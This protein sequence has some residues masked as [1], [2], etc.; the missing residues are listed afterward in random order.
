MKRSFN[1]T[2]EQIKELRPYIKNIDKLIYGDIENFQLVLN[3][4][5]VHYFLDDE[6]TDIS[7][8]LE[9]IY[10]TIYG[11]NLSDDQIK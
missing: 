3:D 1:I 6:P 2:D 8:K 9:K 10:D 7:Y 11:A 4:A 5:I